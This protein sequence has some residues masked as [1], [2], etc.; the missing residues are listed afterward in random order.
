MKT[1]CAVMRRLAVEEMITKSFLQRNLCWRKTEDAEF[2]YSAIDPCEG[3]L[4]IRLN[5][6]PAEPLYTLLC[7]TVPIESFD[8]WPPSWQID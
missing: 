3:A 2:I 1:D 6:F 8:H 5:D 7:G 4:V